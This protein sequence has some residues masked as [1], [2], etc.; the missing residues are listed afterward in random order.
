M[1]LVFI[2]YD[3]SLLADINTIQELSDIFVTH[4]GRL[5]DESG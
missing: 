2:F 3:D 4:C 5:L 1:G